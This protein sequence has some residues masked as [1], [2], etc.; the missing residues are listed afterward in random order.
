MR[1]IA[2]TLGVVIALSAC[3]DSASSSTTTKATSNPA[4]AS[5]TTSTST[6]TMAV[7]TTTST[8]TTM[9]PTPTTGPK[10]MSRD[11]RLAVLQCI[12]A[13]GDDRTNF[14]ANV[15]ASARNHLAQAVSEITVAVD[16]C[17][18][19]RVQ[20]L[21]DDPAPIDPGFD[22]AVQ[23]AALHDLLVNAGDRLGAQSKVGGE[24]F[25]RQEQQA[26]QAAVDS[27]LEVAANAGLD[28]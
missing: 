15:S 12:A 17:T 7:S 11:A 4:A 25:G 20:L 22:L 18:Q 21:A 2:L 13:L 14:A 10:P 5:N 9:E 3:G 26:L 16:A 28:L 1:A 23:E 19:A 8:S 27:F 24:N 6:T